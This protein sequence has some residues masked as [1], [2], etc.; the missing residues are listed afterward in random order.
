MGM[1][2]SMFMAMGELGR[3]VGPIIVVSAVAAWGL[4]GLT[5]L[6]FIGW[7]S[8]LFL[9]WRFRKTSSK[10]YRQK[11]KSLRL[12]LPKLRTL[13]LPILFV[14]IP[15]LFLAAGITT[16]L[17]TFL[18]SEGATLTLAGYS[19]AILEGGGVLGALSS[20]TISDRVGRKPTLLVT[21]IASSLL[22]VLFLQVSGWM[23]Y[24]VL[25][26]LGFFALSLQPV[27]LALVQ[28]HMPDNRAVANGLYMSMS[29]V[30]RSLVLV[31]LGIAGDTWGLRTTFYSI[32]A[33]SL[34]AI[35]AILTLPNEAE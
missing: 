2:M 27:L 6:M 13:F 17:P 23:V 28:D 10:E 33:I 9:L 8:S 5:C 22:I 32:A 7:A 12:A 30:T 18:H 14:L 24:P 25:F 26:L 3:T 4:E 29:F 20:G 15:R 1:G 31:I 16:F 21:I 34:L 19:L 11:P 35:P